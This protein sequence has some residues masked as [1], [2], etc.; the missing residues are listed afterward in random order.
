[1]D[2]LITTTNLLDIKFTRTHA[3][4]EEVRAEVTSVLY[5]LIATYNDA[6]GRVLEAH[7]NSEGNTFI[8]IHKLFDEV[9][10]LLTGFIDPLAERIR[11]FGAYARVNLR[12]SIDNTLLSD[13][14]EVSHDIQGNVT[15]IVNVLKTISGLLYMYIN[16]LDSIDKT[17]SNVLQEHSLAVDKYIYLLQS[18]L[19][20][21]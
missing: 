17:T 9:L 21:S 20:N 15:L 19:F 16:R 8:A 18:N 13:V 5:S 12:F 7:W 2:E 14:P 1:M 6:A 11:S 3:L 4:S 10:D